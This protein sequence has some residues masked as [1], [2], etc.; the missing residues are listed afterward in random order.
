MEGTVAAGG[1]SLRE[2][3]SRRTTGEGLVKQTRLTS[4][5]RGS[6]TPAPRVFGRVLPKNGSKSTVVQ[7]NVPKE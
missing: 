3:V 6:G 2:W 5:G 7:P 4:A 1:M